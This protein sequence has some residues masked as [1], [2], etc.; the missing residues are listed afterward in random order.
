MRITERV[1]DYN[2]HTFWNDCYSPDIENLTIKE[3]AI[4]FIPSFVQL[5][6]VIY[7]KKSYVV[8]EYQYEDTEKLLLIN[9]SDPMF[10]VEDI[11]NSGALFIEMAIKKDTIDLFRYE[12][13]KNTA[14]K[15]ITQNGFSQYYH[16][17]QFSEELREVNNK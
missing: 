2:K 13:K 15:V 8:V 3:K 17:K 4:S 12:G 1:Y 16:L 11:Y 5:Y 9:M 7:D 14:Y 10:N 6:D